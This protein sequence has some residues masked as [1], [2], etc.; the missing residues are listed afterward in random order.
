[1]KPKLV[2]LVLVALAIF[3]PSIAPAGEIRGTLIKDG[4]PAANATIE[5]T[6]GS[7]T[8]SAITDRYGS[9]QVLVSEKGKCNVT[10]QIGQQRF[11]LASPVNSFDSS[12]QYNL[13]LE[14]V[15]G[16]YTLRTR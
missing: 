12:V 11:S 9:Y 16:N 4:A 2:L 13:I 5:I 1:M 3:K 6:N 15:N 7:N 14:K 8:Y 10:V